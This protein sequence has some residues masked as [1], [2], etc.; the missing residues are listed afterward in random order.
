MATSLNSH[1]RSSWFRAE[2]DF[3]EM[4]EMDVRV[5]GGRNRE[6]AHRSRKE[7]HRDWRLDRTEIGIEMGIEIDIA[8]DW[9]SKRLK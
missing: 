1:L 8:R 9:N 2:N 4:G 7:S 6:N 3:A 5:I